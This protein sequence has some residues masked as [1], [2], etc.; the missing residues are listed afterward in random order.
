MTKLLWKERNLVRAGSQ[1]LSQNFQDKD[2]SSELRDWKQPVLS[3]RFREVEVWGGADAPWQLRAQKKKMIDFRILGFAS[4]QFVTRMA[5]RNSWLGG[6]GRLKPRKVLRHKERPG[7]K[8]SQHGR[9]SIYLVPV[10]IGSSLSGQGSS[11]DRSP[12]PRRSRF[13]ARR[14]D[15]LLEASG[16]PGRHPRG[17]RRHESAWRLQTASDHDSSNYNG[18]LSCQR[19]RV[20]P[21]SPM[22]MLATACNPLQAISH[23]SLA[24]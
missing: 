23:P 14:T 21:Y 9:M 8:V 12:V 24:Y 17:W 10:S 18:L 3:Q 7:C 22:R 2:H 20:G 4:L 5:A 1:V 11:V 16:G 15:E 19:T 6:Q 13:C